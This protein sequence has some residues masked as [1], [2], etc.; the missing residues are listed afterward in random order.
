[1]ETEKTSFR[2]QFK[3]RMRNLRLSKVMTQEA[4]AS[5]L[6]L[7]RPTI[8]FYERADMD[9]GRVPDAETLRNICEKCEVSAAYLLG[10][11]DQRAV[12]EVRAYTGLSEEAVEALH[13]L[14]IS[15]STER[16]AI[17]D[18]MLTLKEFEHLL[19]LINTYLNKKLRRACTQF[20]KT[21]DYSNCKKILEEQGF[22]ITEPKS[23][24][25]LFF[26]DYIAPCS[27]G[28]L[29]MLE[30]VKD[31]FVIGGGARKSR[32]AQ[33]DDTGGNDGEHQEG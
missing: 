22:S 30:H 7:S 15:P 11:S 21:E 16:L 2:T 19:G 14:S 9:N 26:N 32:I 18:Y 13:Q 6:G 33:P 31:G 29:M 23:E 24:A 25:K 28:I 20:K 1:M 5:F 12:S 8:S 3:Y 27:R 10:L 4:F 17:V